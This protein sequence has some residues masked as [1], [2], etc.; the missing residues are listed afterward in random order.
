VKDVLARLVS[1]AVETCARPLGYL[2]F[3]IAAL[4]LSGCAR[5]LGRED[6]LGRFSGHLSDALDRHPEVTRPGVRVAWIL[7]AVVFALACSPLDPVARWDELVLAAVA[8]G[9]VWHR[10]F[11]SSASA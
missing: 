11:A 5:L 3:L 10:V 8:L 6:P 2:A 1:S 4:A 7:W 9:I